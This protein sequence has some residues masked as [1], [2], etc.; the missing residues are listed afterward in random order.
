MELQRAVAG[1]L[2]S[3]PHLRD[4]LAERGTLGHVH[5]LL[6]GARAA[7][8]PVVHCTV[9]YRADRRGTATNAP[10]LAVAARHPAAMAQGSEGCE[11][12]PEVDAQ[13]SDV[14]VNRTNGLSPFGGTSLDT[15]LRAL[16]ATAVVVAG[17]SV[18]IGVFGTAVEAVNLGYRVAVA[19]DAVVGVPPAY[20]DS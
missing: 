6:R 17:V 20:G 2:A 8:L 15:T 11:L 13:P 19:T 4:A 14:V 5:R 9:G 12:V 1:D 16:G 7:G 10:M 3:L 18:N